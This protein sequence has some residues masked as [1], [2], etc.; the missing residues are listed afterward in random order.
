MS[1]QPLV[2]SPDN[3]E[4]LAGREQAVARVGNIAVQ[5]VFAEQNEI[6]ADKSPY[7]ST[8]IEG[9]ALMAKDSH[10][11]GVV[12]N[13]EISTYLREGASKYLAEGLSGN[14]VAD[15]LNHEV[16][17]HNAIH[18]GWEM[19]QEHRRALGLD[20][21]PEPTKKWDHDEFDAAYN[22]V[23]GEKQDDLIFRNEM[24]QH[25]T[26][27][28]LEDDFSYRDVLGDEAVRAG[29]ASEHP[30][31]AQ[32]YAHELA[33]L[34][35]AGKGE[36]VQDAAK[37]IRTRF[38]NLRRK[39]PEDTQLTPFA[40]S[41]SWILWDI[42]KQEA[43][44]HDEYASTTDSSVNYSGS[45]LKNPNA[46]DGDK[47]AELMRDVIAWRHFGWEMHALSKN[48]Q[49]T[50]WIDSQLD[51]H[52][53]SLL[54]RKGDES[55]K[56][57]L[58][59]S[60]YID[61]GRNIAAALSES[62]YY[63]EHAKIKPETTKIL[64]E[65]TTPESRRYEPDEQYSFLIHTTLDDPSRTFDY[66]QGKSPSGF[67]IDGNKPLNTSLIDQKHTATFEGASGLIIRPPVSSK[68]IAGVWE[69]D[70][71]AD[72]QTEQL[73]NQNFENPYSRGYTV[74]DYTPQGQYNQVHIRTGKV[75]GVFIRVAADTGQELGFPA[76][77]QA[78]RE[79]AARENLPVAEIAV[80]QRD[81]QE[82]EPY[83]MNGNK[84]GISHITIPHND[85]EYRIDVIKPSG[86]SNVS[87]TDK[88]GFAMRMAKVDGYDTWNR[89]L[90]PEDIASIR[91][92]LDS[93]REQDPAAVA[94]IEKRLADM[95][96]KVGG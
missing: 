70:A 90:S 22:S 68:D 86:D 10:E 11:K 94:Y 78:L 91:A 76:T 4:A 41:K 36:K 82:A 56:D 44:Q 79:L 49:D 23:I 6:A 34:N 45:V 65:V 61:L 14:E 66:L 12:V 92:S 25:L 42:A 54:H 96:N 81:I 88:D 95:D 15:K 64:G 1:E 37:D 93:L 5:E 57:W 18:L 55:R 29:S 40:D 77:N 32:A 43:L 58:S 20:E 51:E 21:E 47:Q 74:L 73:P 69:T 27:V 75:E 35:I 8:A 72:T 89:N 13:Q 83:I 59:S 24:Y 60:E 30:E 50:S 9:A 63:R 87:Y 19:R 53:R 28:I 26:D 7:D 84:G 39:L 48:G 33:R 2:T 85:Y 67:K 62:D 80:K 52:T 31:H 3:R 17:E 16:L 46:E 38:E 71:G